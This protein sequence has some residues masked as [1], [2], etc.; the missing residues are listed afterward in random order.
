MARE[1]LERV[2]CD[3]D[4]RT[5]ARNLSVAQKQMVEI[6]R[7]LQL[8]PRIL[9]MDEPTS[10]LAD[11][12]A[13]RLIGIV[14]RLAGRG[15]GII[16][17]SHRLREIEALCSTVSVLRDGRT[18]ASKPIGQFDRVS[19]V[20]QMIGTMPVHKAARRPAA[21]QGKVALRVRGL[22]RHGA[23]ED[24]NFDLHEGE[25]L[26]IAGLVGSG[27]TELVRAIFGRDRLDAG[28]V[29]V[30]GY[31]VSRPT[32]AK[33][34]RLGLGFLPEERKEQGLVLGM[35]IPENITLAS[36]RKI[37]RLGFISRRQEAGI[38]D[39]LLAR[40][41]VKAAR[42]TALV[43]TLSGGNQQKVVLAKWIMRSPRVL[44]L[45]EPTRGVD[46]HAKAQIFDILR[47]LAAENV[48]VLFISSE[49]EEVLE[50][51][52]RVLTI[53]RGRIVADTPIERTAMRDVLLTA[54]GG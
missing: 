10:S 44:I 24:V 11:A 54:A 8:Q 34:R 41:A 5:L 26:G 46:V 33:M 17:I 16:Y 29:E 19:M 7:A 18:V 13:D 38:V 47:S 27:R 43:Q 22:R 3:L 15:V 6:G 45:D 32:P 40:L 35:T 48:S 30:D 49:L 9:V 50:V 20:E 14:R 21:I 4:P 12:D 52:D 39:G 36:L 2:G 37:A 1:A 53:S 42:R 31:L 25:I 23:F 28:T 51:S